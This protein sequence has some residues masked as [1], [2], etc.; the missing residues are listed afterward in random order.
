M[1]RT[2]LGGLKDL[3]FPPRCVACRQRLDQKE[4]IDGLVCLICWNKIKKNLPPFCNS[5]GRH[6]EKRLVSKGI[7]PACIRK[8]LRFDRAF[9]PC[10]YEGVVKELIHA[11]KY[12]GKDELGSTLGRV[13]I[14]F[15]KEYSLPMDIIDAVVP[16]PLSISRLREREFNQA[17]VLGGEIAREFNKQLLT[18]SLK[19]HRNTRTQTDLEEGERLANVKKSFS[20]VEGKDLKNK[21][22]LLVDDVLTTAA[23]SSEAAS[24]LK[25]AGA[26]IVFVLTLAN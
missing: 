16:V 24:A 6:L 21:N 26:R 2:I 14:D 10:A 1:L 22:I 7:C 23:T 3:V 9:S 4:A 17:E 8:N 5:C 19:R 13:M 18:R 11:F 20:A 12:R 15:A 25:G